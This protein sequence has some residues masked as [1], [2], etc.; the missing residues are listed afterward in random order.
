MET[1]YYHMPKK[2]TEM[3]FT[4]LL[5]LLAFSSCDKDTIAAINN[6]ECDGSGPL[7]KELCE[8]Y[9]QGN[10]NGFS[11]AIVNQNGIQYAKGFGFSDV[12]ERTLYTEN[13]IQNIASISKTFIGIALLKAQE[14]GHLN[15]DD[16]INDYLPFEVKNPSF[17]DEKITIRHLATHISSIKDPL[18]YELN[19]YI[20]KEKQNPDGKRKINFRS[21]DKML[22]MGEFLEKILSD[23]GKWYNKRNFYKNKPG[24]TFEYSNV[25]AS[26]AAYVLEKAT[27]TS[28]VDFTEKYIFMPLGMSNSGWSYD[29]I[30]FNKHSKL[31]NK[32]QKELALYGLVTYPD[33]GLRTSANDMGKYICEL[34]KASA[35]GGII[36]NTTNYEELFTPVLSDKHFTERN[37]ENA[38]NDEYN[39]S[40][41]MGF[42]AK[43][44]IGH[45]GG[46]PGVVSLMFFNPET[47]L[48]Y[49]FISN[50]DFNKNAG[51]QFWDV[52]SALLKHG[53]SL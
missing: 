25:A 21:P 9:K 38:F 4:L 28:F 35:G 5:A 45:T 39:M 29:D 20:L 43:E 49:Y 34:I 51:E 22:P 15:L 2:T 31:Y 3:I 37:V 8:I 10:L 27:N 52:W 40:V 11:V 24:D 50:T 16:P 33:G 19:G 13:T 32:K 42:S 41:F 47:Q 46:D 23:K 7:T 30:D 1:I 53:E 17:E 26:L 12:K 48:G 18:R 14:L 44:Y 36:L 6:F